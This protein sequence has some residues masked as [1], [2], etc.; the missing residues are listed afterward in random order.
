MPKKRKLDLKNFKVKSFVTSLNGPGGETVKGG[1]NRPRSI[2][3]GVCGTCTRGP[4]CEAGSATCGD[5]CVE[6]CTF[7]AAC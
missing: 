6:N 4:C 3:L 2:Q 7:T 1:D 5:T